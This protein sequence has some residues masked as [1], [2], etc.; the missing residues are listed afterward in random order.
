MKRFRDSVANSKIFPQLVLTCLSVSRFSY[1]KISGKEP[2][3]KKHYNY[4]L[5][6]RLYVWYLRSHCV[7][8][9]NMLIH[10]I[11]INFDIHFESSNDCSFWQMGLYAFI[12]V[13]KVIYLIIH[14]DIYHLQ[15]KLSKY[16]ICKWRLRTIPNW[17]IIK[18]GAVL[19]KKMCFGWNLL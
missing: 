17:I 3:I 7:I 19:A 9:L 18:Y 13:L 12:M 15:R 10:Y 6:R 4:I 14:E 1:D 8:A 16:F 2:V 5:N 11:K